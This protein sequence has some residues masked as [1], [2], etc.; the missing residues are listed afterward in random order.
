MTCAFCPPGSFQPLLATDLSIDCN[1]CPPNHFSNTLGSLVC[2]ALSA[3]CGEGY[4]ETKAPTI[5]SDRVCADIDACISFPCSVD[6]LACVDLPPP[7]PN[8]P[9]GRQCLACR[10]GFSGDGNFCLPKTLYDILNSTCYCPG[11]DGWSRINCGDYDIRACPLYASGNQT[12]YCQSNST[13]ASVVDNCQ[14]ASPG[15]VFCVEYL[16]SI[17]ICN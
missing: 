5:S 1:E 16:I 13:Y 14:A 2:I 11:G 8:S 3:P 9:F 10:Q 6:A 12:R 7:A 4:F 17:H 15:L